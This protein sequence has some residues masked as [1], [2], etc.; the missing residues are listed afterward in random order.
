MSLLVS[1]QTKIV[2]RNPAISFGRV[3]QFILLGAIFGSVY[4]KI[5]VDNFITKVR[6]PPF[7]M[8]PRSQ[9]QIDPLFPPRAPPR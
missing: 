5:G 3:F 2:I 8:P 4:Y 9:P 1:R 7:R 6:T